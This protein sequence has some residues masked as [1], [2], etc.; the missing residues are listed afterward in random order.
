MIKD[1]VRW[2]ARQ[3][4]VDKGDPALTRK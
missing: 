4:A 2:L 1:M 3:A